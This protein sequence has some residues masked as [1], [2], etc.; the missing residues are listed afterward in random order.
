[1][2]R[3]LKGWGPFAPHLLPE[4]RTAR[5]RCLRGL[6]MAYRGTDGARINT[7]LREAEAEPVLLEVARLA[8]V[9][10]SEAQLRPI[11]GAYTSVEV[12]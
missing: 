10:L 12:G 5:I 6:V 8:L 2:K 9:E 11:W 1:M 4:E 7:M 3:D